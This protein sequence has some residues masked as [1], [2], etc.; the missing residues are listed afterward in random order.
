MNNSQYLTSILNILQ[1][2]ENVENVY[3]DDDLYINYINR[4]EPQSNINTYISSIS[5][6]SSI[7]RHTQSRL[8][9]YTG[10][11]SEIVSNFISSSLSNYIQRLT[12]DITETVMQ[13]FNEQRPIEKDDT[14][15]YHGNN[16]SFSILDNDRKEL[17]KTCPIC[18]EDFDEN[19]RVS[20]TDCQH[21]Y[22]YDC[23]DEWYKYR[24]NC[25]VCRKDF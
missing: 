24:K 8:P 15:K 20:I 7:P 17:F 23:I 10:T 16:V 1:N 13:S 2:I 25:P 14:V 9:E 19:C 3:D 21:C 11:F 12:D 4:N 5:S 22:H 18:F 6:I